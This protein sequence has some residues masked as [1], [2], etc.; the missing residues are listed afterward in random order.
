[1]NVQLDAWRSLWVLPLFTVKYSLNGKQYKEYF[2]KFTVRNI[3]IL[4]FVDI[5][6]SEM[7]CINL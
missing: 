5:F 7:V 2:L 6:L 4:F 3:E 1:M